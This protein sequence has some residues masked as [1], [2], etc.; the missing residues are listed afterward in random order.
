[1]SL[2]GGKLGY[3][4][5]KLTQCHFAYHTSH[6]TSLGWNPERCGGRL[7]TDC[8]SDDAVCSVGIGD[9]FRGVRRLDFEDDHL[10]M[11]LRSC[12]DLPVPPP[13][14]LEWC[15]VLE[16]KENCRRLYQ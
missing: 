9:S 14:A 5:I 15:A 2:T 13:H 12:G 8:T 16:H 6:G 11:S 10:L 4:E 7:S 3:S 1:M